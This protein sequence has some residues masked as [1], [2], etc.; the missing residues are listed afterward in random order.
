[1][2][3][4]LYLCVRSI[5]FYSLPKTKPTIPLSAKLWIFVMVQEAIDVV[6]RL[7]KNNCEEPKERVLKYWQAFVQNYCIQEELQTTF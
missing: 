4:P 1:M 7:P 6:H 3:T 5:I 2:Q